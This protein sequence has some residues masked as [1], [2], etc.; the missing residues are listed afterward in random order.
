MAS[1]PGDWLQPTVEKVVAANKS[2][3]SVANVEPNIEVEPNVETEANL[4]IWDIWH[5]SCLSE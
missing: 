2:S 3:P 4:A 5:L 1:T